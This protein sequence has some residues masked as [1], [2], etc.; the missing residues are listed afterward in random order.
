MTCANAKGPGSAW[1][2]TSSTTRSLE[3]LKPN[4]D[5]TTTCTETLSYIPEPNPSGPAST[6][7]ASSAKTR[8]WAMKMHVKSARK[9][10]Y[11][12]HLRDRQFS[13]LDSST[14]KRLRNPTDESKERSPNEICLEPPPSEFGIWRPPQLQIHRALKSVEGVAISPMIIVR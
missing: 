3:S 1:E 7:R 2:A 14:T 12:D 13:Q 6:R 5:W 11:S 9:G 8:A 10:K 4:T